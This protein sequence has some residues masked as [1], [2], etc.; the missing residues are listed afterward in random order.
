MSYR[1]EI[2]ERIRRG[3]FVAIVRSDS[4]TRAREV[5]GTLVDAGSAV[6]EVTMTTP[7][8]LSIVEEFAGRAVLGVGTVLSEGQVAQAVG[9]GARFIVTPNLDENVLRA[10]N[11]HGLASLVGCGSVTEVVRALEL[12]ADFVKVFPASALGVEFTKA[13][14]APIPWAALVPTGGVSI[15]NARA[16]IDAGA[17]AVAIGGK[18]CEGSADQIA[19]RVQQ[20][21]R[22]LGD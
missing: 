17:A 14:L 9:A 22:E 4:S 20:L 15:D 8:A 13:V 3:R 19:S 1:W 12:G 16:W 18:L 21:R 2:A 6:V 7:G 10:A 11:R 5:V